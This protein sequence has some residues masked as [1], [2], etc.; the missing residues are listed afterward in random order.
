MGVSNVL[1][2]CRRSGRDQARC[3]PKSAVDRITVAPELLVN[4]AKTGN[5]ANNRP[6]CLIW[7]FVRVRKLSVETSP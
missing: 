2:C 5:Y 6:I 7:C 4:Q 3:G 1:D